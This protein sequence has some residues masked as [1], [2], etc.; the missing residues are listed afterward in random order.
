MFGILKSFESN[1]HNGDYD[2]AITTAKNITKKVATGIVEQG[3]NSIE[4]NA[5]IILTS[6]TQTEHLI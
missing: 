5:K 1:Y 2:E 3:L 4:H 6:K